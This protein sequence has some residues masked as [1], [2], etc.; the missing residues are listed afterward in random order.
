MK[1]T[2]R[3]EHVKLTYTTYWAVCWT[4]EKGTVVALGA[5]SSLRKAKQNARW[6]LENFLLENSLIDP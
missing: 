1:Y 3:Q 2:Q 6:N 4:D 5:G